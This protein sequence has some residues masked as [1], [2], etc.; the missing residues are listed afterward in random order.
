MLFGSGCAEKNNVVEVDSL[1]RTYSCVYSEGKKE[2][3]LLDQEQDAVIVRTGV[4]PPQ[5]DGQLL[6]GVSVVTRTGLGYDLDSERVV[7]FL[8]N[9]KN[10]ILVEESKKEIDA[11]SWEMYREYI[12]EIMTCEVKIQEEFGAKGEEAIALIFG[13]KDQRQEIFEA[14]LEACGYDA[15]L[16][17]A[18]IRLYLKALKCYAILSYSI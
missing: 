15:N 13:L 11:V 5:I 7:A 14:A 3:T 12:E 4:N 1:D 18:S 2:F 8:L 9:E 17:A 10:E 16:K 6:D